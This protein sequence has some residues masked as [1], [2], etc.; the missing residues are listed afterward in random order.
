MLIVIV[1]DMMARR[2]RIW[3][4]SSSFSTIMI[5]LGS[6][7]CKENIQPYEAVG[8]GITNVPHRLSYLQHHTHTK[9]A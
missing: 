9:D 1:I 7:Y 4:L 8:A 3:L 2:R 6:E 5:T